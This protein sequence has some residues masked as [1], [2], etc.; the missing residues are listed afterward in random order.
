MSVARARASRRLCYN[1]GSQLS[2]FGESILKSAE[3]AHKAVEAASEK[4]AADILMLDVRQVC[5][6]AD[7][8]V[9]CSADSERQVQAVWDGVC[10]VLEDNDT[11]LYHSEGA[12]DSGW[13]LLDFGDVIV[14]IFSP[15]QRAYYKLEE[16]WEKG[17]PVVRMQ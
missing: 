2:G 3:I 7:Y 10:R 16:L 12:P 14:H 9:V 4:Q 15:A 1:N 11:K 5:W 6:F 13:V 8:F 17:V